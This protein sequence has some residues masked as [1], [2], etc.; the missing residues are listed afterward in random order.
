MTFGLSACDQINNK[1][2]MDV[3]LYDTY[4]NMG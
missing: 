2:I 3:G 1:N 4:N